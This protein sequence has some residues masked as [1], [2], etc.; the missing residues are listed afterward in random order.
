MSSQYLDLYDF[1]TRVAGMY[2]VR[3]EATER[4]DD[5]AGVWQRFW[6]S[7]HDLFARHPQSA[8]DEAQRAR[9][10]GLRV[11]PH[12][13]NAY[14]EA[15]LDTDV[16]PDHLPIGTSGDETL[17][18][19]AVATLHFRYAGERCSLALYWIDVYGGGLFLPFRD[20]HPETYG[21]GR[22]LVDSVKGSDFLPLAGS[23]ANGRVLID[24]NYAYNP[25]CAYNHRWVCPLAP[26]ANRL[27]VP[28][29]AGE[30]AT[31]REYA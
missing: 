3:N 31:V 16:A 30:Q 21:G 11:F 6:D 19:V 7:R 24:F 14:V 26:P 2:R 28:V 8:L 18:M 27:P 20:T 1:R 5:R 12:D 13:P 23:P 25:S 22:Y 10:D 9:F 17:T 29:A 4:G 15:T